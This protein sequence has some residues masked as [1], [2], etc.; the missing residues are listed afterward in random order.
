VGGRGKG[1]GGNTRRGSFESIDVSFNT[2]SENTALALGTAL[3]PS[4]SA[5]TLQFA[6]L[7]VEGLISLSPFLH[8]HFPVVRFH[9]VSERSLMTS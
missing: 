2:G 1:I 4:L 3:L 6:I 9:F 7:T 8:T 5:G